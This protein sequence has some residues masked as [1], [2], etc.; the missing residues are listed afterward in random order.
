MA[1]VETANVGMFHHIEVVCAELEVCADLMIGI[2]RHMRDGG[3]TARCSRVQSSHVSICHGVQNLLL[4][5]A[6]CEVDSRED[7]V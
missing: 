5:Q 7:S 4:G 6:C 3:K 1:S 2:P